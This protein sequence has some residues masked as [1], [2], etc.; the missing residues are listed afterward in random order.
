MN[1]KN[2]IYSGYNTSVSFDGD[3]FHFYQFI[4]GQWVLKDDMHVSV[5]HDKWK[6]D[7]M[8]EGEL[9]EITEEQEGDYG[10]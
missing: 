3:H 5:F 2:E 6:S 8:L 7:L 9:E 1:K 10:K 4:D